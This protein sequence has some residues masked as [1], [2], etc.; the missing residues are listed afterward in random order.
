MKKRLVGLCFSAVVSMVVV[1]AI[2]NVPVDRVSAQTEP[3]VTLHVDGMHCATCPVTVRLVIGRL[4]GVREVTVSLEQAHAVVAYDPAR[5]SPAQMV[6]A[7]E[8]AGY[9]ARIER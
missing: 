6:Q 4:P 1:A 3:R 7:V 5:V 8:D 2:A 9:H